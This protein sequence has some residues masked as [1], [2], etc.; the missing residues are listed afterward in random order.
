MTQI[1]VS[2]TNDLITDQRVHRTCVTLVNLNYDVLLI[3]RSSSEKLPMKRDYKT[4]RMSLVFSKG[5]LFYAEYNLRLFLKLLFIKKDILLSNDLDTLLPNFLISK[6][7]SKKIVFDSHELF[8]EIPELTGRPKIKWFWK[9]LE[10]QLIPRLK[11]CYTVSESIAAY[12][13]N[14]YGT[15]FK[16]IRNT[17]LKRSVE[18]LGNP[19]TDLKGK[20]IILY[21]GSLNM[22]RGL[23]LAIEAMKK[24]DDAILV[25][26]GKGDIY[27]KLK[28][29]VTNKSLEDRVVFLGRL[30]PGQL[31]TLTPM[32]AI[33]ISIE[34]DLG[35]NYRFTLP[36]KL[37][38]YIQAGIPVLVSDLPEMKKIVETYK[39]G[40]VLKT[41]TPEF[42]AKSINFMLQKTKENWR[43]QLNK[44]AEELVWE[45]EEVKLKNIFDHLR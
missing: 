33:G 22:G 13:D 2:V 39:I 5:F 42:L 21:Q 10:K 44:A 30:S 19:F 32:A 34:E 35:L 11:N 31:K 23:E 18:Y 45:K 17:P 24:V 8:S 37:F 20:K 25:I 12:Y 29:W 9:L 36:N 28:S 26:A 27:Q 16:V 7:F 43:V 3:G 6:I 4:Q 1:I 15:S 38:D 41:R 40:I 14:N